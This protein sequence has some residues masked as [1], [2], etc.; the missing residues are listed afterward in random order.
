MLVCVT[1]PLSAADNPDSLRFAVGFTPSI[2]RLGDRIDYHVSVTHEPRFQVNFSGPDVL[3]GEAFSVIGLVV[4]RPSPSL[5]EFSA[6]LAVFELGELALPS[7][8]AVVRDTLSGETMQWSLE[9]EARLSVEAVT[10]SS[11]TTLLPIRPIR[12][13]PV[14]WSSKVLS[15]LA[16]AAILV[17]VF[18]SGYV[19]WQ[20]F[21]RREQ[22]PGR[23]VQ[24]LQELQKLE[25]RLDRG[26]SAEVCYEQ[27]SL[28]VRRYLEHHYGIKALEEVTS[29]IERELAEG[30]VPG[31]MMF[32]G[33]LHEADMVKFAESR[34][35][36]QDCRN[37]LIQ[38][39][40]AFREKRHRA[41]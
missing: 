33:L 2:A 5:T 16:I 25:Q 26:L 41:E 15:G 9:P 35:S 8:V 4:S 27:L 23:S 14:P 1:G 37:S 18:F 10:D 38:A 31:A 7:V 36:L 19:V 29:E 34:P 3:P 12:D 39:E 11:F 40:N 24:M 20:R 32:C 13:V 30:D 21:S 17:M 28:L 6:S 22:G